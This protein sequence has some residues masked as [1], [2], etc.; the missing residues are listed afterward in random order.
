[1]TLTKAKISRLISSDLTLS[2]KDALKMI[3]KFFNTIKLQSLSKKVKISQ[4]GTFYTHKSPKRIGR[5]PKTKES[6]IIY[7]RKKVTFK[8]SNKVKEILNWLKD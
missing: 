1:M 4:F 5:N 2:K 8:A 6:Y 7:P 3:D